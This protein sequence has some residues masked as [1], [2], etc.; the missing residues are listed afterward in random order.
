M[1]QKVQFVLL[2]IL[3]V[4]IFFLGRL[5]MGAALG[6]N[7]STYDLA[8]RV[9]SMVILQVHVALL[10]AAVGRR[11]RGYSLRQSITAVVCVTVV[12]QVLIFAATA[13]SYMAGVDTLFTFP[14]ALNSVDPVAFN[15]ALVRR[16]VTFIVNCVLVAIAGGIGWALGGLV[17]GPVV[18][19]ER[20]MPS[21][22]LRS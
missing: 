9:F 6:V 2:P 16:T 3:L 17:P 22:M 19:E 21:S 4:V 14:E 15:E 11:Y 12:S 7:K 5:M 13:L 20:K 1:R 10:W 8:N 18:S